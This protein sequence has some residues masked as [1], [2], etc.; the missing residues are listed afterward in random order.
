MLNQLHGVFAPHPPHILSTFRKIINHYEDLSIDKNFLELATDICDFV[1]LNPVPWRNDT[2]D[3]GLIVRHCRERSLLEIY[4]K[5]H[6]INALSHGATWWFN[7]SM[8]NVYFLDEFTASGF[9]PYLIHLVRDGRDVALSFKHAIVGDKHIYHLDK[10]WKE[11]QEKSAYHI[12]KNGSGRAITIYYENLL[13]EPENEIRRICGLLK[14]PYSGSILKYYESEE[15]LLTATSGEMWR[16]L[17]RPIISDNYNKYKSGLL[18][19]EIELF[20]RVA[21]D[22]LSAHGYAL[23]NSPSV[24][25]RGFSTDEIREYDTMNERM[26]Q[27][28]IGHAP[29]LDLLKREKQ[30]AL[31]QRIF[32]RKSI[33]V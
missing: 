11:D 30:Q 24:A 28:F 10:K 7:K 33:P 5:I 1:Q 16:N 8:Q 32:E 2:L 31:L 18:P 13:H 4:K 23:E 20:E 21:G 6:E 17:S 26:K 22:T 29:T 15:S 9:N 3:P 25:D 12:R 27:D 19:G 14:I